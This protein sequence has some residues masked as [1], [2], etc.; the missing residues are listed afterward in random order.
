MTE[1]DLIQERA[2]IWSDYSEQYEYKRLT[3][4]E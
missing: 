3:D 2:Y 4:I 1:D